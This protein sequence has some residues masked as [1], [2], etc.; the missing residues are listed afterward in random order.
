MK[1]LFALAV[2]AT[3]ATLPSMAES[4]PA[5]T[6]TNLHAFGGYQYFRD[7]FSGGENLNGIEGAFAVDVVKHLNITADIGTASKKINPVTARI[8]TYTFGPTVFLSSHARVNPFAH[9]LIGGATVSASASEQGVNASASQNGFAM[10]LGGGFDLKVTKP[11]SVRLLQLDWNDF[12]INS[13]NYK[14]EVSLGTGV[15]FNF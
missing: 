4:F 1:K 5:Q 11:V 2:L 8:T 3:L 9:F 7:G 12:R 6:S 15:V 13:T 10:K 14:D